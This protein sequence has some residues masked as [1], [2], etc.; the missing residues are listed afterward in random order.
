M[1][2]A[3]P[4]PLYPWE[5]DL[6][7]IVQEAGWDPG[8]IWTG[9]ENLAPTGIRSPDRPVRSESLYRLSY[10]GPRIK[11]NNSLPKPEDLMHFRENVAVCGERQKKHV[12]ALCGRGG[13]QNFSVGRGRATLRL[14]YTYDF[15]LQCFQ[16]TLTFT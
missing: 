7:L 8:T 5:R 16:E 14:Q 11:T 1:V 10:L 4:R 3:A 9:A 13:T 2:N 15:V 12:A 6:V